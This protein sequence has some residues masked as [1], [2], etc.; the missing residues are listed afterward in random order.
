MNGVDRYHL[1]IEALSRVDV[2]AAESVRGMSGEFAVRPISDAQNAVETFT[3]KLEEL[4]RS[5]REAGDDPGRD[6]GLDLEP[7]RR[8]VFL[9]R[10]ERRVVRPGGCRARWTGRGGRP[11]AST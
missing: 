7:G 4:R 2:V 11:P 5:V 10:D 3:A 8:C 1:A 9:D 6:Q